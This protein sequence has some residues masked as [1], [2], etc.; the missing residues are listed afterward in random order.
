MSLNSSFDSEQN[1]QDELDYLP[2]H[3]LTPYPFISQGY[4]AEKVLEEDNIQI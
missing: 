4:E 3:N 2:N 1:D